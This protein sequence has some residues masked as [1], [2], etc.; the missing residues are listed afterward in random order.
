LAFLHKSGEHVGEKGAGGAVHD[1]LRENAAQVPWL[2]SGV[3]GYGGP[4]VTDTDED[5]YPVDGG[6]G[7]HK[8]GNVGAVAAGGA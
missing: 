6:G 1:C 5:L 4:A 7:L 3:A 2:T 8:W